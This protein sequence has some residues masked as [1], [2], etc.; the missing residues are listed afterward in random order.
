MRKKYKNPPIS[1]VVCE[2][3][4]GQDSPW[5]LAIP[6]LVYEKVRTIFPIRSQA[7][8]VTMGISANQEGIGQQIGTVPVMRLSSEDERFLMQVGTHLLSVN[9]LKPYS[10][11][12]RFL[13]LIEDS[14]KAYC[15]VAA[16]RSIHRI[17]LRYVNSIQIPGPNIDLED[18]FEFRPYVGPNLPGAIGPFMMTV[19]IPFEDTRDVLNLQLASL[20]GIS[21]DIATIIL[22][23][24]YFLVKSG[25]VGLD[26]VSAWVDSAHKHIGDTFEACITD[27]LKQIFE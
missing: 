21:P 7:T 9:H 19:Q 17:G 27:Q 12:E 15:E 16:P 2:F 14:F 24:D 6:G 20:A 23:L 10:S 26:N 22:D 18:Y 13:P 4:F 11:W 1:E 3:Q 8:R 25:D 5:D